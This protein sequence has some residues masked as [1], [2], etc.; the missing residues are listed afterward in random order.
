MKIITTWIM[1]GFG[2]LYSLCGFANPEQAAL[3]VWVNEAIVTTY[4]FSY[5]NFI[6]DQ[7]QI[8]K[9]FTADAWIAYSNAMNEAKLPESVQKNLYFVRA[10]ATEPPTLNKIDAT[11]WN[12]TM[13]VLVVYENA[14]YKQ[15]QNLK[16]SITFAQAP[17]GRGIRG[18][19]IT[20]FRAV[21]TQPPCQC[22]VEEETPETNPPP[23]TNAKP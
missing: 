12:A 10:V 15:R 11:N 19:N 9:Y 7:K 13:P 5:K 17:A 22:A 4:N 3:S 23:A 14:Q 20:S 21:P 8:A 18:W 6:Q 1:A 2:F 16:V